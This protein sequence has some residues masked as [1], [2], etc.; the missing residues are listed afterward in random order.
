[1]AEESSIGVT[2]VGKCLYLKPVGFATQDNCLGIPCFL[3]AMF[4]QGCTRVAFD[5][6][7]CK[8]MD[9]TFLGIIADAATNLPRHQKTPVVIF[10]ADEQ[11]MKELRTVGLLSL[12]E[13]VEKPMEPP[14]EFEFE[15]VNFMHFP[16]T[17]EE[18]IKE[19]MRLHETLCELNEHNRQKFG[20]FISML[21]TE[22]QQAGEHE[23]TPTG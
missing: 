14:S 23:K 20:S 12:V 6:E 21:E 4:R 22:L 17:E 18:R 3:K 2:I 10:N 9:S 19:V 16:R 13:V 11:N 5:L 8:G 1:M 15:D 7:E